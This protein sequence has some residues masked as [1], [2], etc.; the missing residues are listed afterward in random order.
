[1]NYPFGLPF[2]DGILKLSR[3]NSLKY[4]LWIDLIAVLKFCVFIIVWKSFDDIGKILYVCD[5]K[6]SFSDSVPH[7]KHN[8]PQVLKCEKLKNRIIHV[9]TPM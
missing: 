2:K 6:D 3:I 9:N 1:M 5:I 8:C 4:C 7:L